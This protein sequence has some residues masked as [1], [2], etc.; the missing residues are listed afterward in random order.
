MAI[1]PNDNLINQHQL[2]I[3][4]T[5]SGKTYNMK[6][7]KHVKTKAARVVVWDPYQ[8]HDCIYF[9]N[10]RDFGKALAKCV[11]LP[12]NRGFKIGLSVNP[13]T[14]NF[15]RFSEL[16]WLALDGNKLL[17][18]IVEELADVAKTGKASQYWGQLSR[19]GR[20]YGAILLPATQRPQEVDKTIFTQV[21]AVWVGLLSPY[22]HGYVER[23]TGIGKGELSKIKANSYSYFYVHGNE[24]D[25]VEPR[26]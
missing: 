19:V 4:K 24:I 14:A 6:Q 26:K 10:L 25:Y 9:D 23:S 13:T 1:N 11:T 15:E 5:G 2:F 8:S 16:V 3:G 7:H 17:A 20:K 18:V 22:D 21:S 12:K